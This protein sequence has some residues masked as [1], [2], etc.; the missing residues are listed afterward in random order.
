M[1]AIYWATAKGKGCISKKQAFEKAET[2]FEIY[3]AREMTQLVS[4]F[5]R[6]VRQITRKDVDER[7]FVSLCAVVQK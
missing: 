4:D 7:I 5:D 2:E 3:R 1:T 6:V